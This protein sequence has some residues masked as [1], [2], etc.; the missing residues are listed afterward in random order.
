MMAP[1]F[2]FFNLL[3]CVQDYVIPAGW[4]V[5]YGITDTHEASSAFDDVQKFNPDRWKYVRMGR[6]S[7]ESDSKEITSQRDRESDDVNDQMTAQTTNQT[8]ART[9][10]Q[11]KA[12][13][14][15]QTKANTSE[16]TKAHTSEQTTAQTSEQMKERP[17]EQTS[18]H[19]SE[20]TTARS[21]SR[22]EYIPFGGGGKR[23]CVGEALARMVL[24]VF[25]VEIANGTNGWKLV[26]GRPEMKTAPI[27]FP[28]DHLPI[29]FN[30]QHG[31]R[32]DDEA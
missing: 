32:H 19:T 20:Q 22:Y 13:T 24:S 18:E 12:N 5:L 16:Q 30:N 17:S 1:A 15:D 8:K 25:L 23:F 4:T 21:I 14:S 10:E 31:L 3:I 28:K 11:T 27:P 7:T 6:T 2:N 26:N 9:S 29:L